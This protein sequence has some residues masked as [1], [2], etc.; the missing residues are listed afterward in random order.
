MHSGRELFYRSLDDELMVAEVE[1]D[2]SFRVTRRVML[3]PLRGFLLGLGRALY[4]VSPDDR[5]FYMLRRSAP[6]P[7]ARIML[8]QNFLESVAPP[9]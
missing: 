8:V 6:S 9:R 2:G 3:F 4:T 7:V 5:M 1:G